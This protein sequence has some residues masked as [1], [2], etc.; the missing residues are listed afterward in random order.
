MSAARFAR[1][2]SSPTSVVGEV[3]DGVAVPSLTL[4]PGTSDAPVDPRAAIESEQR[5][6]GG[7]ERFTCNQTSTVKVLT[8]SSGNRLS[9]QRHADRDELWMVLD[10][11]V[12]VEIGGV[13]EKVQPGEK[14]WIPRGTTHRLENRGEQTA[15]VLEIAF[16]HFDECDIERLADDYARVDA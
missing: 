3:A 5:P 14:V 16:G 10:T 2:I 4:V 12:V 6:W 13:V 7:F 8:V 1:P 15:R 11:E 9:L